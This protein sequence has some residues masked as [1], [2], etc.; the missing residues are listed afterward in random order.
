MKTLLTVLI[1]IAGLI[2]FAPVAAIRSAEAL[3]VMYGI[4]E[5]AGDL[6]ILMRHRAL[7]FGLLGGFILVSAIRRDL[8]PAAIVMGLVSMVGYI[9]LVAPVEAGPELRRILIPDLV[10]IVALLAAIPVRARLEKG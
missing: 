4:S 6:L 5:P 3:A 7:L 1:V 10:G 2:N 9:A 8:Q